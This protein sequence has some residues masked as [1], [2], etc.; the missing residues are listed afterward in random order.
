MDQAS[1]DFD[2]VIGAAVSGVA[3]AYE[4]DLLNREAPGS[5]NVYDIFRIEDGTLAFGEW[6]E[7]GPVQPQFRPA[8]F[9]ANPIEFDSL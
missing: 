6:P 8:S 2:F 3:G 1:G 9:P 4:I 7:K 5:T